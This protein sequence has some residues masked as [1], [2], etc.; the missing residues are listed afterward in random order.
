[1]KHGAIAPKDYLANDL[2]LEKLQAQKRIA[3]DRLD[4]TMSMAASRLQASGENANSANSQRYL[5]AVY[6]YAKMKDELPATSHGMLVMPTPEM[7]GLR[8][9]GQPAA[10]APVAP[11][12]T[13]PISSLGQPSVGPAP[14]VAPGLAELNA[15]VPAAKVAA[16]GIIAR[17]GMPNGGGAIPTGAVIPNAQTATTAPVAPTA[18]APA[19]TPAPVPLSQM[20]GAPQTPAGQPQMPTFEG[21]DR[22]QRRERNKWRQTQSRADG[23]APTMSQEAL[24]MASDRYMIDGTLPSNLGKGNQGSAN[25]IA[26]LDDAAKKFAA[27]GMDGESARVSQ[28]AVKAI[29]T[30]LGALERQRALVMTFEKTALAGA[31][32]ALEM[33]EKV[34]RDTGMPIFDKWIQAGRKEVLGDVDVKNLHNATETFVNE[35]AKVMSGSSG[36]QATTVSM[37]EHARQ[38]LKGSDTKEQYRDTI[39]LLKREMQESREKSFDQQINEMK[40]RLTP[41]SRSESKVQNNATAAKTERIAEDANGNKL[42]LRNGQWQPMPK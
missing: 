24:S 28:I 37:Q 2:G 3:A 8:G 33:S 42:I 5:K 40:S 27:K 15:G 10:P 25:T 14:D 41:P 16:T 29:G 18:A 21:G 26:I 34:D 38:M 1:M 11:Q 17:E 31:D 6:D 20:R 13:A 19:P 32:I 9:N 39:K 30:A 36:G 12:A 35:Y 23:N 7:F 4:A 22:E